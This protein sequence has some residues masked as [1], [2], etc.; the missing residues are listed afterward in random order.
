MT[1]TRL[2][3]DCITMHSDCTTMYGTCIIMV[4]DYTTHIHTALS[5]GF[6]AKNLVFSLCIGGFIRGLRNTHPWAMASR[7]AG[8]S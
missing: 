5:V 2:H 1:D 3:S 4:V 7:G 8:P 6:L